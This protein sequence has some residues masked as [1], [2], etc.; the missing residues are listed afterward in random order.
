MLAHP[1]AS[2]SELKKVLA[3][4]TYK[5]LVENGQHTGTCAAFAAYLEAAAAFDA[6]E[7]SSTACAVEAPAAILDQSTDYA[8][9]HEAMAAALA[10]LAIIQQA[11]QHSQAV[12]PHILMAAGHHMRESLMQICS[13][14]AAR[15]RLEVKD[16]LEQGY[17]YQGLPPVVSGTQ[18][19]LDLAQ[20]GRAA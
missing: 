5:A 3:W 8:N 15:E 13:T 10:A 20:A 16:Y 7:Q 17:S 9:N 2:A 14:A 18:Y 12:A 11:L 19:I 4:N 6:E 1:Q